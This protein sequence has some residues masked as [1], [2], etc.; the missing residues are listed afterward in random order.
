MPSLLIRL[1]G[2]TPPIQGKT[3][4]GAELLRV[5]RLPGLD[6]SIPDSSL[7]RVHAELARLPSGWVV[8][9]LGSTNGTYLNGEALGRAEVR[10]RSQDVLQFGEVLLTVSELGEFAPVTGDAEEDLAAEGVLNTWEDLGPALL[11][12]AADADWELLGQLAQV[13]RPVRPGDSLDDYLNSIL[14][15]AAEILDARRGALGLLDEQPDTF[16]AKVTFDLS[17]AG[18]PRFG[19]DRAGLE[20]TLWRGCSLRFRSPPAGGTALGGL[21]RL[22]RRKLGALWLARL[23]EQPPFTQRDLQRLDLLALSASPSIESVVQLHER[24][25]HV[26]LKTLNALAQMVQ[27]RDDHTANH[28]Q[29]VTDYALLLAEELGLPE[30][31][32]QLLRIGTPL[33]DLGKIGIREAVLHKPGALTP[34][35]AAHVREQLLKGA[36]L[37]EQVPSL[38]PLVSIVRHVHERYDGRGYPDGLAGAAIPLPARIVA[39]ADAFDAML[40]DQPYRPAAALDDALEEIRRGAG[41]QFDPECAAAL[42]RLRDRLREVVEQR[43][44]STRTL[45]MEEIRKAREEMNRVGTPDAPGH[46]ARR[47]E[48]PRR[49]TAPG[50]D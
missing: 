8:R 15:K 28:A 2:L 4:E 36:A 47:P 20:A 3:W 45:G 26:F 5:G 34:A 41:A 1:K 40:T 33:H 48:A 42:L 17:P 25:R 38:V 49:R 29:R 19:D 12:G 6:V 18:G 13:G 23:P 39:V 46:G 22:G 7:S 43:R 50:G 30:A 37:L 44:S 11:S 32:R 16:W 14:W 21:L 27:L 9:D 31:E 10:L 35:E 24:Q